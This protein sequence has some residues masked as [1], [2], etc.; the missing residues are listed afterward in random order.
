MT[1]DIMKAL[2]DIR[3]ALDKLTGLLE[4]TA[5]QP[6]MVK[7]DNTAQLQ[8]FSRFWDE[9]PR[10]VGKAEARRVWMSIAKNNT[11]AWM[12]EKVVYALRHQR[13]TLWKDVEP[14]FIP[15]PA[16]WLNQ[17]RWEDEISSEEKPQIK[18]PAF[19]ITDEDL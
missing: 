11:S 12:L 10:K 1:P 19:P 8:A 16:T 7:P 18:I 2:A 4:P 15:H 17:R 14:R 13:R 5:T 3:R 9:Y 6:L